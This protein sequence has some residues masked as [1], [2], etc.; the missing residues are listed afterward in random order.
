MFVVVRP[1]DAALSTEV[2]ALK[3]KVDE[4]TSALASANARNVEL[5]NVIVTMRELNLKREQELLAEIERLSKPVIVFPDPEAPPNNLV[6]QAI[7][8]DATFIETDN[9]GVIRTL[10]VSGG[11]PNVYTNPVLG[12]ADAALFSAAM[13]NDTQIEL[14]LIS[15]HAEGTLNI[16]ITVDNSAGTSAPFAH[17]VTVS[18]ASV[19]PIPN[20]DNTM[21]LTNVSG[22]TLTNWPIRF[23]RPFAQGE[24]TGQPSVHVDGVATPSSVSV[25]SRWGDGSVKYAGFGIVVPENETVVDLTFGNASVSAGTPLST[26]EMLAFNSSAFDAKVKFT[27]G[28]TVREVSARDMLT[29][30][31]YTV[32]LAGDPC[33]E[34]VLADHSTAAT[35]DVGFTAIEA[36]RPIFHATF[37]PDLNKIKVRVIAEISNTEAQ[38][39]VLCDIEVLNGATSIYSQSSVNHKCGTRWTREFWIGGAPDE[40]VNVRFN[41]TYLSSTHQM[42]PY[43]TSVVM[44]ESAIASTYT[45]FLA[46]STA[47]GSSVGMQKSMSVTGGRPEIGISTGIVMKWLMSLGDYRMLAYVKAQA[48]AGGAWSAHVREGDAAKL[49]DQAQTVSAV[50]RPISVYARPTA[51]VYDTRAGN[52]PADVVTVNNPR[53]ATTGFVFDGAHQP[54]LYYELY[55][56]TDDYF[57]LEQLQFWAA[58]G[59]VRYDPDAKGPEPSGVIRDQARGDAWTFRTRMNAAVA[60]PDGTPEKTYF[61]EMCDEAIAFWE[62]R[63]G[64]VGTEFEDSMDW[65]WGAANS[66]ENPL[67]FWKEGTPEEGEFVAGTCTGSTAM[68]QENFV[69]TVLGRAKERGFATDALHEWAGRSHIAQFE[70]VNYDYHNIGRYRTP[71]RDISGNFFE[72]FADTEICYVSSPL[73]FN[74]D[75]S[76]GYWMYAYAASTTLTDYTN[77]DDAYNTLKTTFDTKKTLV[78]SNPKWAFRPPD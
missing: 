1:R 24:I 18:P 59:V 77:G 39:D 56:L 4:L 64:I 3:S 43:D 66:F 62:G 69:I 76:D 74:N 61:N 31:D 46:L 9:S 15:T 34:I 35:Y 55:M 22:G 10:N 44:P 60:S 36:I 50:G 70:D 5:E 47:I 30:E 42:H 26:A 41:L 23:G 21:R 54:E 48:N 28:A 27:Q 49:Y 72:T 51:W 25:R 14:T 33:T 45:S 57:Y 58:F 6:A 52:E 40:R 19:D 68:W 71:V 73:N 8:P 37:Y 11:I 29:A 12:G 75:V 2:T 32:W 13:V 67:H 7:L 78:L 53:T 17:T 65:M 20:P 38:Q 63:F 16:T